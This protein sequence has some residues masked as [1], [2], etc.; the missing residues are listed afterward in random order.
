M[1]Y[2]S[3]SSGAYVHVGSGAAYLGVDGETV[4]KT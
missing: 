2:L 3:R 1:T 4:C